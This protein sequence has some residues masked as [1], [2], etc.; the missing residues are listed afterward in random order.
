MFLEKNANIAIKEGRTGKLGGRVLVDQEKRKNGGNEGAFGKESRSPAKE[1]K[2][3]G[4][5][6][7]GNSTLPKGHRTL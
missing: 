7:S 2:K 3:K 4:L 1:L 6:T 5:S